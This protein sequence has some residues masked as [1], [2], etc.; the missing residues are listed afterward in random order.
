MKKRNPKKLTLQKIIKVY[1]LLGKPKSNV[2]IQDIFDV[3]SII[4][5]KKIFKLIYT[6]ECKTN[7]KDVVCMGISLGLTE[8]NFS[9][10]CSAIEGLYGNN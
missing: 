2:E 10:F 9:G 7:D 8:N 6:F 4:D 5:L 3:Q 1:V